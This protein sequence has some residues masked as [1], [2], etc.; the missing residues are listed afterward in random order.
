MQFSHSRL[1]T[2]E[3]CPRKFAFQYVEKPDV[4]RQQSIEAFMGTAVHETLESLYK[5]VMMERTPKWE[6]VR[7]FYEDFWTK[8]IAPDVLIVRKEFTAEDYR[9]VGRRCLQEYFVKN[10]PFRQ[11]RTLALEEYITVDLDGTGAYKL[12]GYIDRLAQDDKGTVEIHDYKTSRRLPSQ[13]QIDNERQ[14]ALYQIGIE[15]RWPDTKDVTLMWHYLQSGR[16]LTSKRSRESLE[17]LKTETIHLIDTINNAIEREIFP[18][19]ESMLCEWCEYYDLCPAKRHLVATAA[20]TPEQFNA[21]DGVRLADEFVEAKNQLSEAQ[22]AAD[23]ARDRVI[24]FAEQQNLTRLKGHGV[25]VGVTRRK[26]LAVPNQSDP[27]RA[28]L[29]SIIKSSGKWTE[30]SDLSRFKLPKA[31]Q[32]DLFDPYTSARISE[33]LIPRD[34]VTVTARKAAK[35][36]HDDGPDLP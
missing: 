1:G 31:L 19:H 11:S 20:M 25:E 21:D 34:Q 32:G 18:P 17:D 4:P 22:E 26:E 24:S 2:Y 30:V 6:E 35:D 23:Q 33:L 27:N 14:L 3:N 12:Q 8:N 7:D 36:T 10:F 28:M 5:V 29:E 9:N 16:V 15:A 13:E